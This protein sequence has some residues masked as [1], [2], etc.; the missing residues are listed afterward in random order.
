MTTERK[1]PDA[2]SPGSPTI[3]HG[4][5]QRLP[6]RWVNRDAPP[7]TI[8]RYRVDPGEEI[9]LHVHTGKAEYWLVLAGTGRVTVGPD[10]FEVGEG[11]IVATGP[12][13]PHA[14]RNTGPT[15]LLFVNVVQAT[16]GPITTT[17][18]AGP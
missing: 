5:G 13:V 16:G 7:M 8:S 4:G 3:L 6:V 18:L 11:D 12:T 14:L 2:A 10:A 15:P 9:Q 1:P 17:E